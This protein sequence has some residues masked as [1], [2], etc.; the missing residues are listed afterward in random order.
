M[1]R[2]HYVGVELGKG[3]H[4]EEIVSSMKMVAEG[5]TTTQSVVELAQREKIEMPICEQIYQ[6][7]Y[8]KKDP[9]KVLQYLMSR[10]LKSEH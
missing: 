5:I 9:K 4:L 1:S 6:V 7:L 2:N 3:K 8:R 10:K